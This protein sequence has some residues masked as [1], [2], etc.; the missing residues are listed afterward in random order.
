MAT[1]KIEGNTPTLVEALVAFQKDLPQIG[2]DSTNPAFKSKY[3][4]LGA[5]TK[6]MMGKLTEHGFA[7]SMGSF[8]DDNGRMIADAYLLHVSGGSRNLQF[9]ITETNP[10]KIGSALTY[11]RRYALTAL[12]GAVA[13]EDDDGNA[14]STQSAAE[15]VIDKSRQAAAARTQAGPKASKDVIRTDW[16]EPGK[17]TKEAVNA[18]YEEYMGA[19]KTAAQAFDEIL[20]TLKETGGLV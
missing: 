4:S 18:K 5:V 17:V 20:K 2:M 19:G 6:A 7:F 15:R 14:A 1:A 16:I 12:T 8:V 3:A 9:P 13:D 10:Q 11:A